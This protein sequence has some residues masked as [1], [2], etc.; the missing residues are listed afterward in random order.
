MND[1]LSTPKRK[2]FQMDE[3]NRNF[4]ISQKSKERFSPKPNSDLKTIFFDES[5]QSA[6]SGLTQR[7]KGQSRVTSNK[8]P[9]KFQPFGKTNETPE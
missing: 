6:T 4:R 2:K 9:I 5:Q 8:E 3:A 1:F 7:K